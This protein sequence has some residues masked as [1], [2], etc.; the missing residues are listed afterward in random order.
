MAGILSTVVFY[1][2]MH[3]KL[4]EQCFHENTNVTMKKQADLANIHVITETTR[5]NINTFI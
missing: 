1:R 5:E 3:N 4:K 2:S